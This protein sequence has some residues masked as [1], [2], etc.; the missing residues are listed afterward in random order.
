[1]MPPEYLPLGWQPAPRRTQSSS[2]FNRNGLLLDCN[3]RGFRANSGQAAQ[4]CGA[5]TCSAAKLTDFARRSL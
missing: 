1:M 4:P 3:D 5:A 2:L